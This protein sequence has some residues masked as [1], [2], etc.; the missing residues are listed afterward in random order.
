VN[1]RA[2]IDDS[3]E[4]VVFYE[5][6]PPG[7]ASPGELEDR[8]ALVKDVAC[9]V[10]AINIPE[11]REEKRQGPRNT[12]LRQRMEPRDFARAIASAAKVETV[13]NRVTVHDPWAAQ[14]RW[15]RETYRQHGVHNLILVGGES[16]MDH[17]PGPSVSE[18]ASIAAEEGLSFLLGGITIPHRPGEASR[19]RE[20]HQRG[21]RLFTTQVL[22][23]SRDIVALIRELDGLKARVLLSFTPISHARDLLFL[24]K[25]G[26]EIPVKLSQQIHEA[27]SPEQAVEQSLALARGI[28]TQVL[29]HLPPHPPALGLQ[30]ERITKRNSAAAR[31]MLAELGEFYRSQF[32]TRFPAAAVRVAAASL[33]SRARQRPGSR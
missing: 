2:K 13:V 15:L 9:H 23:D 33:P 19:V 7:L 17:Y 16:Q 22:L 25:L 27:A 6:I 24:Q 29:D 21:L 4:P 11:I 20:K 18:T 3:V 5:V 14:R 12:P 30:V 1:L 26:V 8:L 31:R 10:D 32:P 28:F